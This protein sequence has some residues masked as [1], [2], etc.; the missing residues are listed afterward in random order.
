MN[1]LTHRNG[2]YINYKQFDM[3]LVIQK[4]A[5]YEDLEEQGLLIKLPE[6]LKV[7]DANILKVAIL[8]AVCTLK[9]GVNVKEELETATQMSYALGKA[10]MQGRQ[11]ERDRMF[12]KED[13]AE[14]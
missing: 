14:E 5:E 2:K 3:D 8:N 12:I 11:D 1:R 9:Y 10:Y 6:E 4:L 7:I 13:C